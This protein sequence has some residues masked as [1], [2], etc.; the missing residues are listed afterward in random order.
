MLPADKID[1]QINIVDGNPIAW[2]LAVEKLIEIMMEVC[3]GDLTDSSS[4]VHSEP[5]IDGRALVSMA[6]GDR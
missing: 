1:L 4:S 6:V 2:R 3:N 5:G